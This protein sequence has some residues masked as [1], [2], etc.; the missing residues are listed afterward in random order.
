MN[1]NKIKE[2]LVQKD[3]KIQNPKYSLK[4]EISF[5]IAT[6][7]NKLSEYKIAK[8]NISESKT[9]FRNLLSELETKKNSIKIKEKEIETYLLKITKLHKNLIISINKTINNKFYTHLIEIIGDKQKEKSLIQFFDFVFNIYNI[10]R[11]YISQQLDSN[12]DKDFINIF[13]EKEENKDMKNILRILKDETEIR[14]LILYLLEVIRNLNKEEKDIYNK[15]KELYLNI[16]HS[17]NQEEKQYP[18]DCLYDYFNTIFQIVD[19][20]N[21]VENEKIILNNFIK[22]KNTKFVQIKNLETLIKKYN[23]NK[24]IISNDIE[25]MNLFLLKIKKAL[26]NSNNLNISEFMKLIEDIKTIISKGDKLDK[27]IDYMNSFSIKAN[28]T[29][30]EKSSLKNS[31]LEIKVDIK[32]FD[33]IIDNSENLENNKNPK[34]DKTN[35]RYKINNEIF[36]KTNH[37]YEKINK[38]YSIYKNDNKNRNKNNI[39]SKLLG[40]EREVK[41]FNY[42][43]MNNHLSLIKKSLHNSTT[44]DIKYKTNQKKQLIEKSFNKIKKTKILNKNRGNRNENLL[45][46]KQKSQIINKIRSSKLNSNSINRSKIIKTLNNIIHSDNI[47]ESYKEKNTNNKY[48]TSNL[49]YNC[50]VNKEKILPK[51]NNHNRILLQ[52]KEKLFNYHE[53]TKEIKLITK[54][55]LLNSNSVNLGNKIQNNDNKGKLREIIKEKERDNSFEITMPNKESVH[56]KEN[57]DV[58]DLRDSI[59]DEIGSK[60]YDNEKGLIRS[61]TN[62]YINKLGMQKNII[63]TENLYNNKITKYKTNNK[64]LNVEKPIDTFAC[65]ASCT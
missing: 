22:D 39:K 55:S 18:I 63:W 13:L 41:C 32:D 29:C 10:S 40:K 45:I 20:E 42:K 2:K 38:T 64:Q 23:A 8:E 53:K 11:H 56:N 34:G 15:I 60:N 65:C 57:D 27:N 28:A 19:C 3:V 43:T 5:L 25:A 52:K 36:S 21:Q 24:K 51:K 59:C 46:E 9:I 30:N 37:T 44:N 54:K 33:C 47:K 31:I 1:E 26:E 7:K 58:I 12:I 49:T 4:Q 62:N 61:N 6:Y 14:N 50:S 17:I 35:K 16:Y 48:N